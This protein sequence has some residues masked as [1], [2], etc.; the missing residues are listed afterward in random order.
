MK[1]PAREVINSNVLPGKSIIISV[2]MTLF[3]D[4]YRQF[5][6][7]GITANR[8]GIRGERP[9]PELDCNRLYPGISRIPVAHGK[10]CRYCWEKKDLSSGDDR[11]YT[12]H[13]SVRGFVVEC[14]AHPFPGTAG[15]NG[16]Q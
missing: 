10:N 13:V 3:Y 4:I 9:C 6:K 7:S 11:F 14:F 8:E 5:N 12:F 2:M 15:N 1:T 16:L